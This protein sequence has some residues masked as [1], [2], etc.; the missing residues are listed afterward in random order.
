[1]TSAKTCCQTQMPV[2]KETSQELGLPTLPLSAEEGRGPEAG[3]WG[4]STPAMGK[5]IHWGAGKLLFPFI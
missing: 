1:M 2:S 5:H 4:A 3:K